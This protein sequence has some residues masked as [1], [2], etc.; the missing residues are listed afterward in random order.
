VTEAVARELMEAVWLE[1]ANRLSER[2]NP[3]GAGRDALQVIVL[4]VGIERYGIDIRNVT[5]VLS[6]VRA[7]PLP[8][9]PAIFAGVINVHGAIRPVIDLRRLLGMDAG[10]NGHPVRVIVLRHDGREMAL[11]TDSVE[12]IRRIGSDELVSAGDGEDARSPL[13]TSR[14]IKGATKDLLMV[15]G[16]EAL[17]AEMDTGVTT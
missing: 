3:G 7:T 1:R 12:Q 13:M 6:P 9:A 4:G 15:L 16:A 11:Q 5:E 17:F 8:G 10:P 2:P 14:Y